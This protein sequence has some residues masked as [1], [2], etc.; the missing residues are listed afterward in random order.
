MS[1]LQSV[2][3]LV[4]AGYSIAFAVFHL[5]FWRIF[6][7]RNDLGHLTYINRGVV[8]IL[9]LCLTFVFVLF[10]YIVIAHRS[11]MVTTAIGRS[12]LLGISVFWLLRMFEQVWFF[13]LKR[14]LSI[15]FTV[16]FLVGTVLNILP[17]YV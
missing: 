11:E 17:L 10:A 13:G 16:V 4:S 3:L 12:L 1:A 6:D 9:N 2:L 14:P 8:Q 7:W 5:G 15:A